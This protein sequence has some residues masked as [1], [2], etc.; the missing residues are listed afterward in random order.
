MKVGDRISNY[1]LLATANPRG[2]NRYFTC[3]CINCGSTKEVAVSNL[4][5]KGSARGTCSLCNTDAHPMYGTWK[6]MMTR[7]YDANC[8]T[9]K[10]YGGRGVYVCDRWVESFW[11]FYEDM[12]DR[13]EHCTLDRKDN[14]GPYSAEN[15]RWATAVEQ[16]SNTSRSILIE[17]GGGFVTEAEL[18]RLTG[19]PRTTIQCR[20][21]R[22]L[23]SAEELLSGPR[24]I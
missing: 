12:G 23:S 1:I 6:S 20:R 10:Y 17:Y 5:S 2:K 3:K 16:Q 7:C 8:R 15:C 21:K 22:G 18:S 24:N 4:R 13:P 19:V 14:N 11:N 9:Y